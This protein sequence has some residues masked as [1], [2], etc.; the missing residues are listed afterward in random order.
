MRII[1]AILPE[2]ERLDNKRD[3]AMVTK[4]GLLLVMSGP[5]SPY[6]VSLL[7]NSRSRAKC[8][9]ERN[10]K[11]AAPFLEMTRKTFWDLLVSAGEA[12]TR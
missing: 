11:D 9:D 7:Y 12:T 2:E 4:R 8:A 6:A 5:C 3:G 1:Y 10:G